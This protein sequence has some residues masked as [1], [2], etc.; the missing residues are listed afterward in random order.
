VLTIVTLFGGLLLGLGAGLAVF[1][2]LPGSSS[3]HPTPLHIGLAALP[4]LGGFLGGSAL[5]GMRVGRLGGAPGSARRLALAGM[6]GF[7]PITVLL[8]TALGTLEPLVVES[9]AGRAPIHR[10]FTLLFV[11]TAFLIAGVSAASLGLALGGW[12][13]AWALLW[14]VGLA[15]ALAFLAVN[16]TMEAFGWV[17][18]APGAAERATM[19]T[20]MFAG[21]L[22]AA[23]AG[24]AVLGAWLTRPAPFSARAPTPVRASRL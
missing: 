4:A 10:L 12:R 18:G 11:P 15:A 13:L 24:G 22:A 17:V 21:D 6:L 19:L 1:E 16:L 3:T 14:R 2:L 8:G 20:V 5:W 23:L 9:L 7:A